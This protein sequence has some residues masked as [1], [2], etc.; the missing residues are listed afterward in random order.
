MNRSRALIASLVILTAASLA[1]AGEQLIVFVH[2]AVE[3]QSLDFHRQQLPELRKLAEQMKL[4]LR[5]IDVVGEGAPPEVKITPL[6]VYQNWRGRSIYQGR[7]TTIDRVRN[8]IRTSRL[9]PQ[10]A[11][12]LELSD[13]PVMSMGSAKVGS[14][15]KITPL[16]GSVPA[17]F[18]AADFQREFREALAQGFKRYRFEKTASFDRADRLFYMDLHPYRGAD[19][20]F[21]VSMALFSQFH[22]HEPVWVSKQPVS[23]EWEHRHEVIA[24]AAATLEA[25][26]QRQ[27]LA[28]KIGDGFVSVGNEAARKSW[29]ELG[30]S[31][32]EKPQ[33]A[34]Q[35]ATEPIELGTKWQ[36]DDEAMAAGPVVQFAFA[37]PLDNYAGEVKRLGGWVVLGEGLALSGARGGLFAAVDSLSMGEPDL[38]AHIHG[39]LLNAKMHPQASFTF[40]KIEA[41]PD[42]VSFGQVIPG[43]L[44]GRFTL[45]GKAIDLNVPSSIEAYIGEDGQPR[46]SIA[47]TWSLKID[48]PW[49]LEGP[50]GPK[51][52]QFTMNFRANIVLKPGVP[53]IKH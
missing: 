36:V 46:L 8:F 50:P 43:V 21:F 25:Q 35:Q 26:V 41:S 30:L 49:N 44:V 19:G 42:K 28:S 17:E 13:I 14:P 15:I 38:D 3:G 9:M 27:I 29:E 34:V 4:E 16:G 52:A 23:G 31:I 37:A 22:C 12:A 40:E 48:K 1:R 6:I 18:D 45:M 11:G 2:P 10:G 47:A 33:R 53:P 32:P 39:E 7:S 24:Q 20:Q 5:L 51:D